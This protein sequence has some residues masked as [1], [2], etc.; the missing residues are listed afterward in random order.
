MHIHRALVP[1]G[2]TDTADTVQAH[3]GRHDSPAFVRAEGETR[4]WWRVETERGKKHHARAAAA[5]YK[6]RPR[7]RP[8]STTVTTTLR[9]TCPFDE[10]LLLLSLCGQQQQTR[11]HKRVN[12]PVMDAQHVACNRSENQNHPPHKDKNKT[13]KETKNPRSQPCHPNKRPFG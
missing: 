9:I 3:K 6:T 13:K 10:I 2:W 1:V 7:P 11:S 8:P 12:V 4:V 5:I